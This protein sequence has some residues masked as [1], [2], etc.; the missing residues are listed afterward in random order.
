[1]SECIDK[2][3]NENISRKHSYE[4]YIKS[5]LLNMYAIL[6][7]NRILTDPEEHF[8]QKHIKKILPA[9]NYINE[10]YSENITLTQI[11]ELM[12]FDKSHFCRIFK[13]AIKL[14]FIQYVNFVRTY[15]A[16]KLLR[17]TGKTIAEIS[18]EVGFASPSYFIKE[19]KEHMGCTPNYYRKIKLKSSAY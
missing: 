4:M 12:N 17:S 19:F 2:V 16:A 5:A 7:R 15:N 11:S 8:S 13:Q 9:L 1:M 14:S 3:I 18:L 10:N 6:Y